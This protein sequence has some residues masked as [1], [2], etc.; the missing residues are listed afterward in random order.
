MRTDRAVLLAV[1]AGIVCGCLPPAA[2]ADNYTSRPLGNATADR[3][4]PAVAGDAVVPMVAWDESGHVWS[5]QLDLSCQNPSPVPVDHGSGRAPVLGRFADGTFVLAWLR[6]TDRVVV[7]TGNGNLSWQDEQEIAL[8]VLLD[9]V[10]RLDLWAPAG[11]TAPA[12]WL[13][14]AGGP[15][16]DR[17][18]FFLAGG[19]QGWHPPVAVTAGL[20][21]PAF[22]QIVGRPGAAGSSQPTI[23][24]VHPD[25]GLWRTDGTAG[26]SWTEP[27]LQTGPD[28]GFD[29][30]GNELDVTADPAGGWA[31]LAVGLQP[32]CPCNR[33]R[34]THGDTT[35]N[36]SPLADLTVPVEAYDWP[37]S[38]RLAF[39]RGGRLH[40]FW[41]Q[42]GSD[43]SM[44]PH[45]T[46]L[47]HRILDGSVWQEETAGL[48]G[49]ERQGIAPAVAL[50]P[51][52]QG[53]VLTAW[54]ERDTIDA[55]PQPQEIWVRT[56]SGITGSPGATPR[57]AIAQIS[58]RPNPFNPS[59]TITVTAPARPLRVE[60]VDARGRR[61]ATL[62]VAAA[63]GERWQ[64]YWDGRDV[65]G[66]AVPSG[67]YMVRATLPGG[68]M[69]RT[70]ITL[71]R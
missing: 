48:P 1:L 53:H 31:L 45:S 30:F 37:S 12:A 51:D 14:V 18:I 8:P 24:F 50:A 13:T 63:G 34:Y 35:G 40:A 49:P 28:W 32:T 54:A 62:P 39:D 25:G 59:V 27:R 17:T 41:H 71:A 11:V 66:R 44:A 55:V 42:L 16:T 19:P 36:W 52:A 4:R 3:F 69:A 67:V 60:I 23:F 47:F 61:V 15:W 64:G 20:T 6:G 58:A 65:A 21:A 70:T 2:V 5:E 9:E 57:P 38:P 29:S 26:V 33:I 56:W 43:L 7:T 68:S 46:R 22:P 10:S